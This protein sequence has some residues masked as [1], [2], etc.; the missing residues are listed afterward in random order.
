MSSTPEVKNLEPN[1]KGCETE[2]GGR[3]RKPS[4]VCVKL[5]NGIM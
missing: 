1:E 4:S 3:H 5:N 2:L